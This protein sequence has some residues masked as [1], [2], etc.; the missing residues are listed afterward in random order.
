MNTNERRVAGVEDGRPLG[1]HGTACDDVA[2]AATRVDCDVDGAF[3]VG[4]IARRDP[5]A[6]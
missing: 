1:E 3:V 2:E 4:G 5:E 6:G